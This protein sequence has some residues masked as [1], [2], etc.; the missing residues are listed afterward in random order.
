MNRGT[1]KGSQ[2]IPQKHRAAE[3]RVSGTLKSEPEL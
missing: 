3:I 1:A 2:V